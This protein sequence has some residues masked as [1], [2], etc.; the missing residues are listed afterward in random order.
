MPNTEAIS[1]NGIYYSDRGEGMPI[2]L[3]HGFCGSSAYWDD[4]VPILA[5]QYRVITPDLRGHGKSDVVNESFTIED[6]AQDFVHLLDELQI[7]QI[8]LFGHSLG[9]YITLAFAEHHAIRLRGFALVH[10]TGNEDAE[11]AKEN[12]LKAAHTVQS[13]GIQAFVS[14]LVP[15]LFAPAH[16]ETMPQ[17]V[18]RAIEIGCATAHKGAVGASLAMRGRPDRNRVLEETPLPV[19]LVAGEKDQIIAPDQT[20]KV[21]KENITQKLIPE[22]GHMSMME[23]PD[24]LSQ[25]ILSYLQAI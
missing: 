8:V 3:L 24:E 2:V 21:S 20:F 11:Q 17:S 6:M 10:S 25:T 23:A 22:V 18:A 12:R 13:E 19:L 14:G 15:K 1:R 7:E 9:G 4:V 16:V 5:R